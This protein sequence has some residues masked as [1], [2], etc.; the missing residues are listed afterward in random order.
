MTQRQIQLPPGEQYT[1]TPHEH[2]VISNIALTPE[3]ADDTRGTL[4]V[5]RYPGLRSND[6]ELPSLAYLIPYKVSTLSLFQVAH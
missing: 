3:L 5:L 1:F 6:E 4:V 2:M